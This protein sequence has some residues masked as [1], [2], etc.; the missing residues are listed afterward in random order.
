MTHRVQ[1]HRLVA[2]TGMAV[3]LALVHAVN[4]ALAAVLG[5]L[6]PSI[7]SRFAASATTLALL[8][9][10]VN[11]SAS[12]T[13]PVLGALSDRVGERR[14]LAGGVAVTAAAFALI[15]SA[16]SVTQLVVLLAIGGLGSAA[17]HPVGASIVG[18]PSVKNPAQAVG[19]F[20]AGGMIGAAVGPVVVLYLLATHGVGS[21]VWL[22]IPG[23]VLT[24]VV[25]RVLPD[26]EPHSDGSLRRLA[27]PEVL[28]RRIALL[29]ASSV[30]VNLA[31][32]TFL[33][34]VPLWLVAEHGVQTDAPLLGWVLAAF[35]AA[36][37]LGA[38]AGGTFAPRLGVR[39]TTGGSMLLA[40]VPL[41]AVL[42]LPV[43]WGTVLA[44]TL[45]GFLVYASQPL[46]I[47]AA[48]EA[49]PSSPAAAGGLVIGVGNALA[50]VAYVGSGLLQDS[51]GLPAAMLIS[52]GLLVPGAALATRAQSSGT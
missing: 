44:A 2:G 8:V 18:G 27:S 21:L 51:I 17:L 47:V 3:L 5:S 35:A 22:M 50:A 39:R 15:G 31:F 36:S 20:T 11:I 19:L 38:L 1:R 40:L 34:A 6:L 28:S 46:L 12:V 41:A 52:F 23:L 32:L 10:T 42:V 37:G 30:L 9:A 4:D 13:Q 14:M 29:T 33:S 48:Q 43:G 26:W 49:A 24:G 16:A 7:Q 25:L 45:G